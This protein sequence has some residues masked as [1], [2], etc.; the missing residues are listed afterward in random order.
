MND[1]KAEIFQGLILLS[2]MIFYF[3]VGAILVLAFWLR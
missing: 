1:R 2:Q 3:I